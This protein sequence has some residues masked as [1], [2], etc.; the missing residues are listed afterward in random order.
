MKT[1]LKNFINKSSFKENRVIKRFFDQSKKVELD[2]LSDYFK[3]II[4]SSNFNKLKYPSKNI[5][6]STFI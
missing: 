2:E 1:N 3:N 4:N 5:F 6:I